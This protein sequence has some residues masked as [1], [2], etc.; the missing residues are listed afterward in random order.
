FT[1]GGNYSA[2]ATEFQFNDLTILNTDYSNETQD[3]L[4]G[5]GNISIHASSDHADLILPNIVTQTNCLDA[6]SCGTLSVS[7]ASVSNKGDLRIF[8]D[9]DFDVVG[10]LAITN[11]YLI[12]VEEPVELENYFGGNLSVNAD[13][14]LI[15]AKG[16]LALGEW[17]LRSVENQSQVLMN[18]REI[19]SNIVA[20]Q[21][22]N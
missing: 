13:Y 16:S 2:T 7:A 9:A 18:D 8:G 14:A 10:R 12:G 20:N 5:A 1:G 21:A 6:S 4:F 17:N 15:N 3:A 19:D 22:L 11:S